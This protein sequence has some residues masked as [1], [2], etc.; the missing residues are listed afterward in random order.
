MRRA[1]L[2]KKNKNKVYICFFFTIRNTYLNSVIQIEICKRQERCF[3][4]I[5]VLTKGIALKTLEV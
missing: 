4:D 1:C 3:E 2:L 5:E